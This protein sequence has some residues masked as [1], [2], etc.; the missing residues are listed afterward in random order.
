MIEWITRGLY[1]HVYKERLP[2]DTQM[3]IGQL[4]IGEWLPEFVSDM[5]RS[6]V[7]GGQ[8][9]Y[10]YNRMDD[11]PTVSLWVYVFHSRLAAM[12]ITNV[13]LSDKLIAEAQALEGAI[14]L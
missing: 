6:G 13:P 2:P 3:H 5:N 10:A 4:R 9:L 12:A 7:G 11:H 14:Q 1:W 8:F